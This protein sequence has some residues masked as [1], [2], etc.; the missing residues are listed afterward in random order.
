M[1]VAAGCW[2]SWAG[3]PPRTL[4]PGSDPRRSRRHGEEYMN[5]TK[6]ASN[7]ALP[8][9]GA[10]CAITGGA[11]GIGWALSEAFARA[12]AHVYACDI[13]STYLESAR[14]SVKALP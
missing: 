6:S 14:D 5:L 10:V 1:C 2:L 8:L 13:S 4:H 11:Q 9:A 3:V 7:P 12:G